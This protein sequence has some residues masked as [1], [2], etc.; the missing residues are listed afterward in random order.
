MRPSSTAIVANLCSSWSI[1]G[2]E[3]MGCNSSHFFT[4]FSTMSAL[5]LLLPMTILFS[6]MQSFNWSTRNE[7]KS[8]LGKIFM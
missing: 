4:H 1:L 3:L 7:L 2:P 6:D 8:G 5:R